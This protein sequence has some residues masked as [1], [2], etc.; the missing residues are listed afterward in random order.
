MN[1][2]TFGIILVV[3]TIIMIILY[4]FNRTKGVET[5][6]GH[7][8]ISFGLGLITGSF[9]TLVDKIHSIVIAIIKV[10]NDKTQA[11]TLTDATDV[12]YIQL[13]TGVA[14]VALGIWFIYKLKNRIYILNINGY[15]DHRIENN[16]KSLGLNEFDF[17]EREIEFVKR[18]T[19]AQDNSMEQNVVPEII[20][21][22]VFKIEAFK[23]ESANVKRGY[24]GIAP[25]PFIL[26][27][28]KLFN[29]HKINHFYERNKLK[30]DY[31]KLANKKKNFEE[32]TLQTNLQ[33][34]SSISA[35]EAI[36][37]V[38]LTFDIS[39]HDTSQFGSNV[40]VVD[41][42]VDET[43]ENIIQGKDQLEE[44]VK[45]VYETIRKI[46]Q[47]NPSIQ[48]VHLL[49]ASQSC[50]PF[51]LGKLLDDTSMPEVIS[52]HFVNPR[53]K[54]G[55]ILNKHNKGTFVTAP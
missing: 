41:L 42:K 37:K 22:L 54:W 44:Y 32:L 45:V 35:T 43:K 2:V 48:R 13:V 28:G 29:G 46:N 19:K 5:F 50:L 31:Y 53:Y 6:G 12:N 20:E 49:I 55:I 26:Y 3:T 38:S 9:G 25:I 14:F 21:E 52:Y 11:K 4:A 40:P 51:E 33:A 1:I 10:T 36:L 30:Q 27:A 34:L 15:A 18:F 23:N 39:T 24:T 7:T 17:K 47:S 8:F 16:Q